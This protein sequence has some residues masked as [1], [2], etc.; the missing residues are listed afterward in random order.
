MANKLPGYIFQ[1]AK[2]G[3]QIKVIRDSL[4]PTI[5]QIKNHFF[6]I[7][8]PGGGHSLKYVTGM[9]GHIDPIFKTPLTERPPFYFSH[10]ALT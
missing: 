2:A 1:T 7:C 9:C 6:V 5:T 4:Y 8:S 10:F 3:D